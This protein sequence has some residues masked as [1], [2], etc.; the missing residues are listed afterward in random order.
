M[1]A[2]GKTAVGHWMEEYGG[3]GGY[4]RGFTTEEFLTEAQHQQVGY[5][6]GE[7]ESLYGAPL[8]PRVSGLDNSAQELLS[9]DWTTVSRAEFLGPED[10]PAEWKPEMNMTRD[11]TKEYIKTWCTDNKTGREMRFETEAL[12]AG[13]AAAKDTLKVQRV[14][15][16]PGTPLSIEKMRDILVTH[17]GILAFMALRAT[18]PA[19][20]STDDDLRSALNSLGCRVQHGDK[21]IKGGITKLEFSQIMTTLTSGGVTFDTRV[22]FSTVLGLEKSFDDAPVVAV[23]RRHFADMADVADVLEL[24]N[25]GDFPEV[26][27]GLARYL[28]SYGTEGVLLEQDFVQAHIDMFCATPIAYQ[29]SFTRFWSRS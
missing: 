24:F 29:E 28:E 20:E 21:T 17:N 6:G 11:A 25:A 2:N 7:G 22:L 18:L 8:P 9:K 10:R 13:N 4:K 3:P 26:H 15:L 1:Y 12:R 27:E 23:F 14:R 19:D 16:L 5:R